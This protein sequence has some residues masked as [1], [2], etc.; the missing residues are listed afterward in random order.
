MKVLLDYFKKIGWKR[1][2]M[3]FIGNTILA[4]GVSIF[5][6]SCLGNDA[7]NAMLMSLS[8][9]TKIQ[10][11]HF[12]ALFSAGLFIIQLIWG[13][14]YIG[15]GTIVNSFLSG[16]IVTFFYNVWLWM[17]EI[18][19][20]FPV[21]FVV[22]FIGVVAC[23]LGISLYQSSNVG[24]SPYDFLSLVAAEKC[25]KIPYFWWRMLTDATCALVAFLSGGLLGI[26]TLVC[27]F[28][29]G[30]FAHF[31][32]VHLAEKILKTSDK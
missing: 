10:Y 26:G 14:S 13:R 11:G 29:L 20:A 1:I 22:M 24:V 4:M 8:D 32:N 3:V 28:G 31:F 9:C 7:Y 12:S 27:A 23:G 16:Y 15:L 6:F 17:F 19:T 5:K 2:L 21:R 18:P 30:P 25:K